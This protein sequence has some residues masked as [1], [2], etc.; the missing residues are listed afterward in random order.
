M[1]EDGNDVRLTWARWT[2]FLL[3]ATNGVAM[4]AVATRGSIVVSRD[5]A[6]TAVNIG[7]SETLFRLA[8]IFDLLLVVG[9]IPL[10]AGLY[11]VLKPVGRS[12]AALGLLWRLME[13]ALLATLSLASFAALAL[14]GGRDFMQALDSRTAGD[15][16][17][18]ML[19]VH[20]GGLQ[21]GFLFLGLG[22]MAFSLLWWKSRYVPRW[23][24]GLGILGSAIMAGMAVGIILWPPLY[25]AATMAYM[26]PMG[27]YEIG[28][29][30]WLLIHG[31]RLT[32]ASTAAR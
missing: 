11:I 21:A 14:I 27:I 24:A 23:L 17:Y 18:A 2:G 9:M 10:L 3:I 19:R 30:L 26:A 13:T 7:G 28:L 16:A 6:Q 15:I 25:A 32:D 1:A 12:L 8:I 31:I 22:Q 20:G 5:A 4:A 29:G